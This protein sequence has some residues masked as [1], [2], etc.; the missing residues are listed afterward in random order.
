MSLHMKHITKLGPNHYIHLDS[1]GIKPMS[2]LSKF[3]ATAFTIAIASITVG[4]MFGMD[5]TQSQP[6][7]HYGTTHR[8]D[9]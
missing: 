6:T 4:A 5:I 2:P 8:S 7:Q 9:R 1:Y 3:L